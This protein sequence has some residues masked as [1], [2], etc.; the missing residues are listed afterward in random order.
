[1]TRALAALAAALVVASAVAQTSLT[2]WPSSNPEEIQFAT[3]IV[4][5]WNAAHPDIQVRMQPLPASRSTE[6]VLLA[7]IAARTTP[8]VAANIYPGAISQFVDA[9]GLYQHDTLPGFRPF[10]VERSGEAVVDLYTH[11]SGHVFQ[12][13]WKA[14][15]VMFAYNVTLLAEAGIDPAD[16]ATYSGFLEAARTVQQH[17]GGSKYLYAPTVDVTWWQRFFDFYTLYIAA[18]GGQT[19]LDAD[20]AVVFD[21][22]AGL[23]VFEFLATLF[24]EGL[25]PK[26]QTAQNRF[27]GGTAL[28]EQAGPFTMPF[29]ERNAPEGFEFALIPP[30]VPDARAGEEVYTYG[31]PKNIG[32]FSTTRHPEEAWQF[33]QFIL[34]PENDARFM[35]IT[36]QIPYRL[37][38][39]DDPLFSD[40]LAAR[41][42]LQPFLRQNAFT[43]GVDDTPH[44]IEIFS[45]ISREYEAAV[46]QGARSPEEGLRRAAQRARDIVSGFY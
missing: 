11:P 17:W 13:P 28:L 35:H 38:M 25:A 45:A 20:G 42:D 21:G 37:G 2:F 7:A 33:I 19:L 18:S 46:V 43:R 40:I 32:I 36:G 29:Y 6:E 27:F 24:R 41:P 14:N 8:D 22:E 16:L 1:M 5:E 15:P 30:P 23:A 10:M 4:A 3:Q 34:S 39:E 9:G 26:G 12:I 44:L 31:D